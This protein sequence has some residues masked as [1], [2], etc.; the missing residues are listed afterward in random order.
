MERH[1][2]LE[3]SPSAW[4]AEMLTVKHQCRKCEEV[5]YGDTSSGKT[6]LIEGYH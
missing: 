3:P 4:K 5:I 2:G 6:T 1:K